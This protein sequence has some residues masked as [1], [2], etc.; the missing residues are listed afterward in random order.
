MTNIKKQ[1]LLPGL[2]AQFRFLKKFLPQIPVNILVIGSASEWIAAELARTGDKNVNLIVGDY[3]SLINSKLI[4]GEESPVKT[5]FMDFEVTDFEKDSLDLVYA[6]ASVSLTNRNK[7]IK[8]I[9]R[10]LKPGG[11]FCVG[12]IAS[13]K[14]EIPAFISDIYD[15]SNL[16]PL[17]IDDLEKYYSERKFDIIAKQNLS[18]TLKEYYIQCSSLLKEKLEDLTDREKSYYKKL[19]NKVS[20]E[21]NVYLKLG[22]DKYI[23]FTGL[24]LRKG[25]N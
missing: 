22:G 12:E 10:I 9:K 16:L 23:G 11:Y 14:K 2:K 8:E 7:I 3:E 17:F 13:L 15:S 18:E 19:L 20:H 24:L 6:Q 4:L 21:S 5:S 1:T 25:E